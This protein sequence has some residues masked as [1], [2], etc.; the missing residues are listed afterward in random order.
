MYVHA[1]TYV[2]L[3]YALYVLLLSHLIIFRTPPLSHPQSEK[4]S[5]T[6]EGQFAGRVGNRDS[7]RT[8]CAGDSGLS[9]SARGEKGLLSAETSNE[10]AL[11]VDPKT[12]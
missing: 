5:F 3:L 1:H 12:K 2:L 11:S 10:T 9:E 6:G 8:P 4:T 7:S